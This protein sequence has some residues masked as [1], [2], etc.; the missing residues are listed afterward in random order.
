ME[1]EGIS[2]IVAELFRDL[3]DCYTRPL[4]RHCWRR[5]LSSLLTTFTRSNGFWSDSDRCS[6]DSASSGVF[7][8]FSR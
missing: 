4:D 3:V 2:W 6:S 7:A 8:H 5:L 1:I